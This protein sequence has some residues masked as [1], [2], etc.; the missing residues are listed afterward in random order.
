MRHNQNYIKKYVLM[1][2]FLQIILFVLKNVVIILIWL[3]I[4]ENITPQRK[5]NFFYKINGL[6]VIN[7]GVLVHHC[8]NNNSYNPSQNDSTLYLILLFI[9]Q[10]IDLHNNI[11]FIKNYIKLNNRIYFGIFAFVIILLLE[12]VL[13]RIL[14]KKIFKIIVM[15]ILK[16]TND[17][18]TLHLFLI[19]SRLNLL[20]NIFIIFGSLKITRIF[21]LFYRKMFE[22]KK[23]ENDINIVLSETSV[24]HLT[25]VPLLL[26]LKY[27]NVKLTDQNFIK[28]RVILL[29]IL[30]LGVVIEILGIIDS[31]FIVK[32]KWETIYKYVIISEDCYHLC[33]IIYYLVGIYYTIISIIYFDKKLANHVR[34]SQNKDRLTIC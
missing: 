14:R 24:D 13:M 17:S 31:R 16:M 4:I 8:N 22:V 5:L 19:V 12:I 6:F 1:A 33:L 10:L 26:L 34:K 23:I 29:F 7:F 28:K 15:K 3:S 27:I 32:I 2:Q 25:I 21:Y 18:K 30:I 9:F 11:Y 20:R